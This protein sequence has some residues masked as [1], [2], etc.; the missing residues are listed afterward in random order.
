MIK[1][2]SQR[3]HKN[4]QVNTEKGIP[5][6]GHVHKQTAESGDKDGG[7]GARRCSLWCHTAGYR[8]CPKGTGE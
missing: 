2:V 6:Q 5:G 7:W 8:L 4:N 1:R 3:I